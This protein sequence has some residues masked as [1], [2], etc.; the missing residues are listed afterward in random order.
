MHRDRADE[1]GN[2][3]HKRGLE[4]KPPTYLIPSKIKGP[5][6]AICAWSSKSKIRHEALSEL[7]GS[8]T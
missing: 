6:S 4:S 8:F 5:V 7:L 1:V 3:A 2:A